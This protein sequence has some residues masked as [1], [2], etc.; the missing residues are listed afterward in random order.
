MPRR[1]GREACRPMISGMRRAV[2]ALRQLQPSACRP[3]RPPSIAHIAPSPSFPSAR[4]DTGL[5]QPS[6]TVQC[7]RLKTLVSTSSTMM[8]FLVFTVIAPSMGGCRR[9]QWRTWR[10]H[11]QRTWGSG[12]WRNERRQSA[13]PTSACWLS[14]RSRAIRFYTP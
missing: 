12:E 4:T 7:Q 6:H 9:A 10:C 1:L 2:R 5:V 8:I 13:R 3:W 14:H 11:N